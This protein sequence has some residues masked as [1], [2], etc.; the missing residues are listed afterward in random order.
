[1]LRAEKESYN[2]VG[3]VHDENI[4][5]VNSD[6]GSIDEFDRIMEEVPEWGIGCPIAAEG[7]EGKRYKK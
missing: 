3:C 1:M 7:Y 5:L 2:L 6:F 4:A